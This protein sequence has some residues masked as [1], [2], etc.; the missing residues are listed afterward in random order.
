MA[1]PFVKL[2]WIEEHPGGEEIWVN[3]STIAYIAPEGRDADATRIFFTV[4]THERGGYA[5]ALMVRGTPADIIAAISHA[6]ADD[7]RRLATAV[8]ESPATDMHG[9]PLTM[10]TDA[11]GG[12]G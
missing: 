11:E 3:A 1:G 12:E 4:P 6:E 7:A 8:A 9:A 10:A 2:A 5:L